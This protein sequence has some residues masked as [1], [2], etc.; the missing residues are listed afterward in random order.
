MD[1]SAFKISYRSAVPIRYS[2]ACLSFLQSSLVV[3]EIIVVK[4]ITA[5]A[6]SGVT[7]S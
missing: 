1:L 2:N 6:R 4:K 7:F 5:L 3:L